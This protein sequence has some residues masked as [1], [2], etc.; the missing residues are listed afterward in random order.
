M[1]K[2]KPSPHLE[3]E[4]LILKQM[5]EELVGPV[6]SLK[7]MEV[8]LNVSP[9]PRAYDL[10]LTADFEDMD[11]LQEYRVHP[12]HVKILD[13]LKVI[14]EKTAAVDYIVTN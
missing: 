9:Q 7:K 13:R 3:E 5:L 14:A 12:E 6:K 10:V 4:K 8:G 11:G 1:V 2:L